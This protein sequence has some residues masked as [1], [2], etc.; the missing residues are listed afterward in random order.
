MESDLRQ[1]KFFIQ[2]TSALST[3]LKEYANRV[4]I[5]G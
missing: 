1:G 5:E 2:T 4:F 3:E